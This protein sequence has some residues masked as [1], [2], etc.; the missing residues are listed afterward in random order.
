[1][2]GSIQIKGDI[3]ADRIRWNVVNHRRCC[4]ANSTVQ[5]IIGNLQVNSIGAGFGTL[6]IKR[7]GEGRIVFRNFVFADPASIRRTIV[8]TRCSQIDI[9]QNIQ[10]KGHWLAYCGGWS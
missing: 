5:M 7:G 2:T 9:T 6:I 10:V 1:M 3:L 4:S 8:D